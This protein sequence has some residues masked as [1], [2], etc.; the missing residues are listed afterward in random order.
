MCGFHHV[1]ELRE[2]RTS[3][4]GRRA[5]SRE[6]AAICNLLEILLADVLHTTRRV[7][8]LQQSELG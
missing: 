6:Q 8:I 2:I 5:K 7:E 4:V 1:K 3:K